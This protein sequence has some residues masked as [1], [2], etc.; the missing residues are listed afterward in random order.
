MFYT[1][2]FT[3][4]VVT[5]VVP[6]LNVTSPYSPFF[7]TVNTVVSPILDLKPVSTVTTFTS[8]RPYSAFEY[9]SISDNPVA[10]DMTNKELR[11]KFL[12][13]WIHDHHTDILKMMKIVNNYVVVISDKEADSNDISKDTE[14]DYEQKIDFIGNNI[15]TRDKNKKIL[16]KICSKNRL[17]IFDLPHNEHIVRKAQSRYVKS[18][19]VQY[20]SK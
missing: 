10:L 8:Y 13:K 4:N 12:D 3:T 7:K 6:I 17:K 19:L 2:R 20:N 11:Y 15:L 1:S 18:K 16:F 14:K 9:D 5:P